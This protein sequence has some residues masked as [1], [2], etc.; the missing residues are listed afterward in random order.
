MLALDEENRDLK[1]NLA[2]Q[3]GT[4]VSVRHAPHDH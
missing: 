3:D 4:I 2:K 1:A